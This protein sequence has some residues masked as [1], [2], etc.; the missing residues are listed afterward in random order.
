MQS[1][2]AATVVDLAFEDPN[3]IADAALAS[4]FQ[5]GLGCVGDTPG[6]NGLR[7]KTTCT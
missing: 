7:C 3:L 5:P 2:H 4:V 1:S 6:H